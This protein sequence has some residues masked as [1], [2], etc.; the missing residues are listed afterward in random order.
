[1]AKKSVAAREYTTISSAG[2]PESTRIGNGSTL[3][4]VDTGEE[5]VFFNG[6]WEQDFRNTDDTGTR[7]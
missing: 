3:H 4:F 2:F 7:F 1:M 5:Y 6:M